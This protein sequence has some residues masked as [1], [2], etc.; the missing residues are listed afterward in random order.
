MEQG[1]AEGVGDM[2]NGEVGEGKKQSKTI[3]L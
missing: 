3:T 2:G 1:E